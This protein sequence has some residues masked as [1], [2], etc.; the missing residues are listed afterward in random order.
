MT[1]GRIEEVDEFCYM[2]NVL[3]C[4]AVVEIALIER[5]GKFVKKKYSIEDESI[6]RS[7]LL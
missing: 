5:D 7:V 6:I 4:E 1:T 2:V 3:D